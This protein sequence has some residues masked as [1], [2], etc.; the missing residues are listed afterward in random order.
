MTRRAFSLALALTAGGAA[1]AA[2]H[3]LASMYDGS[4]QTSIDASVTAFHFVNPHPYL[5]VAVNDGGSD[6]A[7]WRLELDNRHE[8]VD[9]GMTEQTLRPGDR[10]LVSGSPGRQQARILY[11]RRLERPSDGF[12]YEQEGFSP[13]IRTRRR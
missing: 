5:I 9:V 11:V 6:R 1:P 7:E 10:V 3:S 12:F 8:L 13:R 4:R 2:H